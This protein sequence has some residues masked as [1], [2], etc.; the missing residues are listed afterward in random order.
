MLCIVSFE[1]SPG[2]DDDGDGILNCTLDVVKF[3][4]SRGE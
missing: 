2:V 1:S 3:L 4:L